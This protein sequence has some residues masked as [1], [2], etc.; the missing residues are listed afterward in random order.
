MLVLAD[1]LELA[2][3]AEL[4]Y[5]CDEQPGFQRRRCGRGF[6][7]LDDKGQ[8]ITSPDQGQRFQSLV[9][10]PGWTQV[11]I[12]PDP[13]GHIQ[14]TGRDDL[15]R[16][17]YIYHPRWEELSNQ[18]KFDRMIPFGDALPG[19]RAHLDADLRRRYLP[20]EKVLALVIKLLEETLIRVGNAQYTEQNGSYGLTT[21]CDRH[22]E[23]HGASVHFEFRGKSGV[24][25]EI[26]ICDRRLAR[27]VKECQD[28]PG[29]RLFQY[30]DDDGAA[31]SV[32]SS[33]VNTYLREVTGAPITAKDFRTWGGTV[34]ALRALHQLGP[35]E[36][37]KQHKR[38]VVAAIRQVAERLGNTPTVC[39]N[40]YVHPAVVAAYGDHSLFGAMQR[41]ARRKPRNGGDLQV[42]E[43]ALLT[44]LGD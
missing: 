37:E 34:T 26:D 16:K 7:Y 42:E 4:C 38:N 27:L 9:I 11:W 29:Q 12:C 21:L 6:V 43:R 36:D 32:G 41:A 39:R 13:S 33:D 19:L 20:R 31:Q 22:I 24:E 44:I 10:P 40:Y 14:V 8:R 3:V 35:C 2:R 18:K 30:L 17:Q 28:L 23:V 1:S 25:R 15:G 5:V